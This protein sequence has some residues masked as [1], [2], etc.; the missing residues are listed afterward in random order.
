MTFAHWVTPVAVKRLTRT[1]H[2]FSHSLTFW[3]LVPG[4]TLHSVGIEMMELLMAM[5]LSLSKM[6]AIGAVWF[7]WH[8][9]MA[10]VS[11]LS[12]SKVTSEMQCIRQKLSTM[13]YCSVLLT[14]SSRVLWAQ[15]AKQ[16]F[17]AFL[18]TKQWTK[19]ETWTA[20]ADCT[21]RRTGE[22]QMDNKRSTTWASTSSAAYCVPFWQGS[23]W[24]PEI[25]ASRR[26]SRPTLVILSACVRWLV[27][28]GWR[29]SAGATDS[30]MFLLFSM[31][32]WRT[33]SCLRLLIVCVH[34][35]VCCS[36]NNHRG[37]WLGGRP[38]MWDILGF[39]RGCRHSLLVLC[40]QIII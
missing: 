31:F 3:W 29:S 18:L 13:N 17:S 20:A 24:L 5:Q 36:T 14:L 39:H 23:R 37:R 27:I 15:F 6:T 12:T 38:M 40:P 30:I 19:R 33:F 35:S 34:H 25:S 10:T 22:R 7:D 16:S 8:L 32:F 28:V 11:W 2:S 21:L 26:T 9:G 4:R 1:V